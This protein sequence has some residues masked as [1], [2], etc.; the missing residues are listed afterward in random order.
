MGTELRL[1][2]Q[3]FADQGEGFARHD[4]KAVFISGGIPGEEVAAEIVLERRHRIL[5][6]VVEVFSPSPYR[7]S[8]QC[9]LFGTCSGCQWQHISYERQLEIKQDL[10]RKHFGRYFDIQKLPV[11]PVF[12]GPPWH[13]RNHNRYTIRSG[14]NLGFVQK[15]TYRF[16]PVERCLIAHEMINELVGKLRGHYL[17]TTQLS[18]RVGI[19]TGQYLI[20]PRLE[21][22]E[23]PIPTGQPY[24]EEELLGR[25][26]R[27]SAA[28]FFQ[29]NTYQ[30][31]RIVETVREMMEFS[32]EELV[33]DAYAGVG[34]LGVLMAPFAARVICIEESAAA[35]ADAQVNIRGISNLEYIQGK[36]E[37]VLPELKA[38]CSAV[39]LDPPRSG[40][41]KEALEAVI[42]LGPQRVVYVSCNP[43][44]LARDLAVLREGGYSLE[45][46][47]PIDMFPQT[48]HVEC[49]ALAVRVKTQR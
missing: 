29:V 16:I 33:I 45:R 30:A 40:C 35:A 26:F 14:G 4:G 42:K 11:S 31:E 20:Q 1:T 22:S 19:N 21:P 38:A 36:T 10:I 18:V 49:V 17:G 7:I 43:D 48:Y 46:L 2:V 27:V 13:Y 47:Q 8:P 41:Q 34:T 25:R 3:D 23:I 5:A 12:P 15:G 28:S 44:T 37:H 39:I 6:R 9:P 32:G 24:Y